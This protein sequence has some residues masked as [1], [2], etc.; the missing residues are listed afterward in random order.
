MLLYNELQFFCRIPLLVALIVF[1]R[2]TALAFVD[3]Q[4]LSREHLIKDNNGALW[5]RKARQKTNQMCNVPVLSIPQRILRKYEDNAECI[6]KGVLLPVISNQRMN[7]YLK[8]IADLC[9][10]TKRLTTHVA[11]H[12]AATIVFLANDVSM[13]N[14]SKILGHSNLS[15]YNR[16]LLNILYVINQKYGLNL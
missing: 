12:T 10:I 1:Y 14:V 2:F 7:A 8:E 15:I 6:K 5:I 16:L 11:R 13:E 3:V 4:Q 9:G